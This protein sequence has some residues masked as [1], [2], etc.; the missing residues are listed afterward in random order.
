MEVPSCTSSF[1]AGK[2]IAIDTSYEIEDIL[3]YKH[4][5]GPQGVAGVK[6][7]GGNKRNSKVYNTSVTTTL[8]KLTLQYRTALST[9]TN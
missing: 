5:R 8:K 4:L 7:M 2:G 9:N 1:K 3:M 6:G